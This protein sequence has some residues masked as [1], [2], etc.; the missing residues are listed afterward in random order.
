MKYKELDQFSDRI[1]ILAFW[2]NF[3]IVL[4]TKIFYVKAIDQKYLKFENFFKKQV[5]G[6]KLWLDNFILRSTDL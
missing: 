2:L 1:N 5:F 4:S 6:E 3:E